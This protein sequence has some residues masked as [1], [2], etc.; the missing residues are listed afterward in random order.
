MML[1]ACAMSS[2][3]V[4][5]LS[6]FGPTYGSGSKDIDFNVCAKKFTEI[7][8]PIASFCKRNSIE[9]VKSTL[10]DAYSSL[11]SL[12]TDFH[13]SVENK[14]SKSLS[15]KYSEYS[16]AF[17]GILGD[18]EE[19]LNEFIS[20]PKISRVC[21]EILTE[22]DQQF[23]SISADFESVGVDVAELFSQSSIDVTIWS[24]FGFT[25]QKK[26]GFGEEDSSP[27]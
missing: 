17:V 10:N 2:P 3:P 18:F 1:S 25:F 12:A 7:R 4:T 16:E 27:H 21:H 6:T 13:S 23:D 14:G 8:K 11:E 22:Y 19:V 26:Y 15:A 24:Y 9:D 20:Y 5:P